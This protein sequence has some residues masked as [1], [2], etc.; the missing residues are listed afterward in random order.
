M[1][2]STF[3]SDK[4]AHLKII[5]NKIPL[6]YTMLSIVAAKY[7]FNIS[8]VIDGKYMVFLYRNMHR[9][10]WYLLDIFNRQATGFFC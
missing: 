7:S 1:V 2:H 9:C 4:P 6:Y 8:I 5:I 3:N 10:G